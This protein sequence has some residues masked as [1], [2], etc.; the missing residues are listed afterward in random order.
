MSMSVTKRTFGFRLL[1]WTFDRQ[2]EPVGQ[3]CCEQ[4]HVQE[5]RWGWGARS[6]PF[7]QGPGLAARKAP[8]GR[9]YPEPSRPRD[10]AVMLAP[11][12]P[13]FAVLPRHLLACLP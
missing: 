13:G 5:C 12:P 8:S 1:V 4:V 7:L 11:C 6:A 10:G 2:S 3:A 9:P